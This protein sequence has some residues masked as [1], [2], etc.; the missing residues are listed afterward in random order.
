[1]SVIIA[2]TILTRVLASVTDRKA[3][4]SEEDKL[5]FNIKYKM[6]DI[7]VKSTEVK[8]IRL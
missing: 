4:L 1:M 2:T 7:N 5:L 8:A 6:K 3:C